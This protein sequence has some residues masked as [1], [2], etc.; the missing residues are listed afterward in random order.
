[1]EVRQQILSYVN[2]RLDGEKSPIKELLSFWT[3]NIIT[4][5][6][7]FLC[8]KTIENSDHL[9]HCGYPSENMGIP[10]EQNEILDRSKVQNN[11]F[12]KNIMSGLLWAS[13]GRSNAIYTPMEGKMFKSLNT[14]P[15]CHQREFIKGEKDGW[16]D[17]FIIQSIF[18]NCTLKCL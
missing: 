6:L 14:G 18:K 12:I 4:A 13:Y 17:G 5:C 11:L 9:F 7:I 3:P 10:Y 2:G 15:D 8:H 1:M 16:I